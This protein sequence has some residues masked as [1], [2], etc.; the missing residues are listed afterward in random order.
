MLLWTQSANT[1]V[2][3]ETGILNRKWKSICFCLEKY[4]F[5][6]KL[7]SILS[8]AAGHESNSLPVGANEYQVL[9]DEATLLCEQFAD[10]WELDIA[11]LRAKIPGL[12]KLE[13]LSTPKQLMNYGRFAW[14]ALVGVPVSLF[15][16]GALAGLVGLG[17]HLTAGGR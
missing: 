17:F 4:S 8:A 11:S 14:F 7:Q 16:I 3:R 10:R 15:I 2:S 9:S 12:S 1:P 6:Q 13:T 5:E